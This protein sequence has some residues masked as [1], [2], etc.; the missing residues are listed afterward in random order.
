MWKNHNRLTLSF[1]TLKDQMENEALY[2]VSASP[3]INE[4]GYFGSGGGG[5]GSSGGGGDR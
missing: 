5:G 3:D 1:F 2:C 4:R